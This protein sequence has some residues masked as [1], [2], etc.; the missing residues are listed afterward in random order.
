MSNLSTVRLVAHK[1]HLELLDIVDQELWKPPGSACFAF[2]LL[3]E[4]MLGM[5][6]WLLSLLCT[7]WSMPLDFCQLHSI[8]T[9]GCDGY[10]LNFLV[11]LIMI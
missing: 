2:L 8:L 7:L 4:L 6:I 5:E 9:H 3:L 10:Q 11:L 1:Q